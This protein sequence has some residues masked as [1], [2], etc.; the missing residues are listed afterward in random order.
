MYTRIGTALKKL[1]AAGAGTIVRTL[2]GLA[3]IVTLPFL[4][5]ASG[6]NGGGTD[7][8]TAQ[9]FEQAWNDFDQNYSYFVYKNVDWDAVKQQYQP[10]FQQEMTAD[11]FAEKLIDMLQVLHDWHVD[12]F[13]P[14]GE[15]MGYKGEYTMN[16]TSKPRNKYALG[17]GYKTLGEDVVWYGKVGIQ[18]NENIGYIRIDSFEDERFKSVSDQDIENI[19]ADL[20][21]ADGIII[22]IRP[23]NGGGEETAKKFISHF[24]AQSR[25]YGYTKDRIPGDD[26]NAFKALEE[27]VLEPS[28]A[29]YFGKPVVG[30]IGQRCMSSAE[31][32]TLMM[33][34]CPTITLIGDKTRGASAN[35]NLFSLKN[36]VSYKISSWIAYTDKMVE[37]EDK[38]IE[39]HIKIASDKS[40]DESS[41]YV[42]ERAIQHI[43]SG[44]TVPATTTI[45]S[46]VTTTVP[47]GVTT[48]IPSGATTTVPSN[49]TTTAAAVT[50]T[51]PASGAPVIKSFKVSP[52]TGGLNTAFTLTCEAEDTD[53][54]FILLYYWDLD[55]DTSDAED[56]GGVGTYTLYGFQLGAGA[57]TVSVMVE[58]DD[59]K[60][61]DI[62]SATLTVTQ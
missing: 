59:G 11:E 26:H 20:A 57:H 55:G 51:I 15:G 50:T 34:A 60:Q 10:Q 17:E 6:C 13:K 52:S 16:C 43:T 45:P 56:L 39:P 61:S 7:T 44:G 18:G 23:N 42:L 9:N 30:L 58:D 8:E 35:P 29:N 62:K 31:W 36:N 40:F 53:G 48:T 27:H 38:G 3:L 14:N 12:V 22:D 28:A 49:T 33:R 47:S 1:N 54:G 24:T 21:G 2:C 25:L 46:G 19:F 32:C 41:D 37:I 4:Y 5:G